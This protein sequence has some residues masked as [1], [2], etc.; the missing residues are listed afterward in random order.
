MDKASALCL[1]LSQ[2]SVMHKLGSEVQ[3]LHYN[4]AANVVISLIV[5]LGLPC[6]VLLIEVAVMLQTLLSL[7]L[8]QPGKPLH[9]IRILMSQCV[10]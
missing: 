9:V 8:V 10:K 3:N 4:I 2:F 7:F 6:Y 1:L 5:Q